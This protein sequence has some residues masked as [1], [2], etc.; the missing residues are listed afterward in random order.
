MPTTKW[1]RDRRLRTSSEYHAQT[2]LQL[3]NCL[4]L[5][6]AE[7]QL[8]GNGVGGGAGGDN[9]PL[10]MS[11]TSKPR[12]PPPPYREPLPGSTYAA[13]SARPSVITQAPKRDFVGNKIGNDNR[14]ICVVF[15]S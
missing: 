8:N 6:A 14:S 7:Q 9:G 11:L 13:I 12:T 2:S 10:D 1:R 15:T 5:A 4:R 3:A